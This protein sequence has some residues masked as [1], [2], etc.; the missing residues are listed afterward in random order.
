MTGNASISWIDGAKPLRVVVNDLTKNAGMSIAALSRASGV[1]AANIS[2][3]FG[4]KRSIYA[5]AVEVLAGELSAKRGDYDNAIA[6]LHR[7][8]LLEDNFTGQPKHQFLV[9][10]KRV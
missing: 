2:E 9:R 3:F 8:V 1:K 6:R 7:G 5:I 4:G 10:G